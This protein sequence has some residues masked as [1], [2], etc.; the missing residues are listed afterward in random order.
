MKKH[1]TLLVANRGE[2]ACRIM[3]TARALG[4]RCVAVH[5][6]ADAGARHVRLA[7]EAV[8]IGPSPAAQSYLDIPKLVEAALRTGAT[9]VHPGYGF[10]SE[11]AAFAGACSDAGIVF[12]GP[13][14]HA[15]NLMGDKETAR[16][17]ARSAG[18]PVLPGSGKLLASDEDAL[19]RHAA[20]V[21]FPLL[22][23]ASA[24]GGGIGIRRVESAAE[25][26]AA[27]SSTSNLAAKSFGDGAIYLERCIQKA[28]HVEVQV[29]GFGARGA[30][31][32]SDRDCSMQRRRQKVL[33]EAPA[34]RIP[35]EVR[36]EMART[37][38]A[39]ARAC[40]YEGAGTIEFLFDEADARFYFMEMNTRL[41]VEHPVTE[42]IADLDLVRMQLEL[43]MGRL[44]DVALAEPIA[45]Q[46]HAIEVRVCA[47]DPARSF[48]PSPGRIGRLETPAMAGLRVDTG[49][50]PGD[51]VS[52]Y[53]DNLVMKLITHGPTR[54]DALRLMREALRATVV[55][56]ISTNLPLLRSLAEDPRYLAGELSTT[57]LEDNL[58]ELLASAASQDA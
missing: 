49:F 24:G 17:V 23:K 46:G 34:P 39:L 18:V 41:Q 2:I 25:L 19:A 47:E 27:A 44:D 36:R 21:G 56:G 1:T 13:S 51:T 22:V 43:A 38:T 50:E 5:S 48:R 8:A 31:A 16:H 53:Y 30:I 28:R 40:E 45:L 35:H 14:P 33:E 32:I 57:F 11:S 10:L 7:D 3:R 4:L 20:A 52:P 9:L 42:A 37:A 54:G 55:E 26:L 58:A 15:L 12:V 6:E 29:F